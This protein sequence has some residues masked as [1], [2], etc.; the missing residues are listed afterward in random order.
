VPRL[1]GRWAG[2]LTFLAGKGIGH[3]FGAIE[4]DSFIDKDEFKKQ[5]DDGSESSELANPHPGPNGPLISREP[6]RE[7]EVV[8]SK[9]GILV[10]QTCG[11]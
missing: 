6:E 2:L 11:L 5:I 10:A 1:T 9:E 8:R 7:G 3:F 4:I